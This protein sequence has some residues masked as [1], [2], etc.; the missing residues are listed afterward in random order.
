M[1]KNSVK[2]CSLSGCRRL[3]CTTKLICCGE[4]YKETVKQIVPV[5]I[6]PLKGNI[7]VKQILEATCVYL[8]GEFICKIKHA[9][10]PCYLD[11]LTP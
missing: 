11:D 2:S 7:F 10:N 4:P 3:I 5:L 1:S 8:R 9:L 6:G